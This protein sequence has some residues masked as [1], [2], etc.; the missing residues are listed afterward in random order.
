MA[1]LQFDAVLLNNMSP[2]L[3]AIADSLVALQDVAN[4]LAETVNTAF[5]DMKVAAEEFQAQIE[6]TGP[7]VETA[8]AGMGASVDDLG[9]AMTQVAPVMQAFDDALNLFSGQTAS[10]FVG[11]QTAEVDSIRQFIT[12]T[13]DAMDV[14]VAETDIVTPLTDSLNILVDNKVMAT[15]AEGELAAASVA[16]ATALGEEAAAASASGTAV[17][18]A[19]A[20]GKETTPG[21]QGGYGAIIGATM[22]LGMAGAAARVGVNMVKSGM[23]SEA[24]LQRILALADR[25]KADFENYK[26]T[27]MSWAPEL[28]ATITDLANGMY[29][30]VSVG[31]PVNQALTILHASA[32]AAAAGQV[33][34]HTVTN[35]LTSILKVYGATAD[36][37]SHYTDILITGVREGKAPFDAYS[38]AIGL[39]GVAS[40]QANFQI[41][42]SAA[43]LST[44]TAVWPS[45]RQ[46]GQNLQNMIQ[47]I[48]IN[49]DALAKHAH[50]AG[51]AFDEQ[52]YSS[53]DLQQ[54]LTYLWDI[55]GK[56][57]QR[58]REI[59]GNATAAK[60][61]YYLA[62]AGAEQFNQN[63]IGMADSAGATDEAFKTHSETMLFAMQQLHGAASVL[64]MKFASLVE[65]AVIGAL[66]LLS[67]IFTALAIAF[68]NHSQIMTPLV[69]SLAFAIG[70]LLVGAIVALDEVLAAPILA[71]AATAAVFVVVAAAIGLVVG[72]FVQAYQHSQPLRDAVAQLGQAMQQLG[73]AIT[74][75]VQSAIKPLVDGVKAAAT[76]LGLTSDNT[77]KTGTAAQQAT[78]LVGGLVAVIKGVA[79]GV[80]DLATWLAPATTAAQHLSSVV[81]GGTAHFRNFNGVVPQ[82]KNALAQQAAQAHNAAVMHGHLKTAGE[83][84]T[85]ILATMGPVAASIAGPLALGAEKSN[86][87]RD[88]FYGFMNVLGGF[89]GMIKT[90]LG[91]VGNFAVSGLQLLFDLFTGNI[92]L[93]GVFRDAMWTIRGVFNSIMS[94]GLDALLGG[95]LNLADLLEGSIVPAVA[96]AVA[97]AAP[98]IA[99]ALAIAA[100]VVGV[101]VAFQHFWATSASFRAT[102]AMLGQQLLSLWSFLQAQFRPVWVQLQQTFQSQIMPTIKSLQ[103]TWNAIQPALIAIGVVVMAILI[104]VFGIL[105]SVVKAIISALAPLIGG[106]LTALVGAFKFV[107]GI[108]QL[109]V[110]VVGGLISIIVDLLFNQKNLGKD[111]KNIWQGIKDAA[112][113]IFGGLWGMIQGIFGG[114]IRAIMNLIGT[115]IGSIIDFFTHLFEKLVG[116]SV[117]P[118]MIKGIIEWFL[119]LPIEILQMVGQFVLNL[120]S[121]FLNLATRILVTIAVFVVRLVAYWEAL[122]RMII[123]LVVSFVEGVV[124]TFISLATRVVVTIATFV[125][126][127]VA[128]FE[129]LGA[130]IISTIINFVEGAV[131]S[132]IALGVRILTTVADFVVMVIAYWNALTSAVLKAISDWVNRVINFFIDLGARIISTVENF[133]MSVVTHFVMLGIRV[134]AAIDLLRVKGI[135]VFNHYKDT[136]I[137]IVKGFIDNVVNFFTGLKDKVGTAISNALSN[138]QNLFNNFNA[139]AMGKKLIDQIGQGIRNAIPGMLGAVTGGLQK[140]RNLFPHS[141]AKEGPLMTA[142]NWGGT[143]MDQI[144]TGISNRTPSVVTAAKN[145]AGQLANTLG[146]VQGGVSLGVGGSLAGSVLGQGGGRGVAVQNQHIHVHLDGGVGTGLSMVNATDRARIVQDIAVELGKQMRLQGRVGTGYSGG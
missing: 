52:K 144:T 11:A 58:F 102:I 14:M 114:A 34:L 9:I 25:S 6:A 132:F 60:A 104:P 20:K 48:G 146:N 29:D 124:R 136:V 133:V 85:G 129:A 94:G 69:L 16:A 19:G 74:P 112:G 3:L 88:G 107:V 115:F 100:V 17:A 95:L 61:A 110:T 15:E 113:N 41:G 117:V 130:Q 22:L 96:G 127:V 24:A 45:V 57:S 91:A 65:P 92:P 32:E 77:K 21:R 72:W 55:S 71:A 123:N 30:I 80:K 50:K 31:Y 109:V 36:Q 83:A 8:F 120:I 138:I 42:E 7:G 1:E 119:K 121:T 78:G 122:G 35:G 116:H 28:G 66:D 33:D 103:S 87:I 126:R 40:R 2:T 46:A 56:N 142:P 137:G 67:H 44:L 68:E 106:I 134:L 140:L 64:S 53:M 99:I 108:I 4:T 79:D 82:T 54:K 23:D 70:G 51:V 105:I 98:F 18:A 47:T 12:A 49:M 13:T 38:R 39:V 84:A 73:T 86:A 145:A 5:D 118:D 89:P 101:V 43:A 75:L 63:L 62:S 131:N 128:F 97:A 10:D 76:W 93:L 135:E 90:A 125:V 81:D 139:L 27:I 59:I 26:A 37:A 143:L 141:P 111:L